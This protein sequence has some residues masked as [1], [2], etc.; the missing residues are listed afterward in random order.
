MYVV[1]VTDF[2][3]SVLNVTRLKYSDPSDTKTDK[4]N[5]GAKSLILSA[6][7]SCHTQV[8]HKLPF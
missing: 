2:N 7:F 6:R 1:V 4:L 3:A 8:R 5:Y